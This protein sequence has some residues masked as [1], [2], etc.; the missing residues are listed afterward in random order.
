MQSKL[1]IKK[2]IY[3]LTHIHILNF[4]S[5]MPSFEQKQN[6]SNYET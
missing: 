6:I 3:F 5:K 2:K 4:K 1:Q